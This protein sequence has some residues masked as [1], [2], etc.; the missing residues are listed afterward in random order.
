MCIRDRLW[1]APFWQARG[2][3]TYQEKTKTWMTR[4]GDKDDYD[5]CP[6]YPETRE[7]LKDQFAWIDVY[8]RQGYYLQLN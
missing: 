1:A 7:L 2:S 4:S 5:L 8:K 6:K 3:K